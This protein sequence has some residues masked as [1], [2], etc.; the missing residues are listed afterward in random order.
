MYMTALCL[1]GLGRGM[2]HLMNGNVCLQYGKE[3][4]S[5]GQAI[6]FIYHA[7]HAKHAMSAQNAERIRKTLEID[8]ELENAIQ[9]RRHT[10]FGKIPEAEVMRSL[11]KK[12]L[13][14]AETDTNN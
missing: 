8:E 12:G 5:R 11:I 7:C 4:L 6:G 9:D 1:N 3:S 14:A 13:D 10:P 2:L